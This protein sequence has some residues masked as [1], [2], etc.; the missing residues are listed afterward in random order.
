MAEMISNND[1]E[2]Y[3]RDNLP[4][5]SKIDESTFEKFEIP[6]N[7]C[8]W[9]RTHWSKSETPYGIVYEKPENFTLSTQ[10]PYLPKPVLRRA[11]AVEPLPDF[12]TD[13][14]W[15]I[16]ENM[17][18]VNTQALNVLKTEGAASA[19]EFMTTDPETGRQLDYGEI[20]ARYG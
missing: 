19:F 7:I 12:S 13:I 9:I 18:A 2:K 6:E 15:R 14:N 4:Y 17:D 3:L 5:A 20:R 10:E 11:S 16:G 8:N 1:A